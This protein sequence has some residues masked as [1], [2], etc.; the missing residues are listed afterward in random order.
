MRRPGVRGRAGARAA[1]LALALVLGGAGSVG[2]QPQDARPA[3]EVETFEYT[4]RR[5]DT[6]GSLA[7]RFYGSWRL[8]DVIERFNPAED[9]GEA[10]ECGPYLSP[11]V[12]L[13]LPREYVGGGRAARAPTPDAEVTATVRR[14]QAR[15]PAETSWRRANRGLDLFRGWRVNTLEASAAELTFRDESIV[16]MREN[17]LV[18]IYGGEARRARRETR[19]A[20]LERGALRSRLAELRGLRVETPS[21]EAELAEGEA[22]VSVDGAGTSRVSNLEGREARVRGRAG[23]RVR[24]RPGF[25]SKVMP[26]SRP[27]PPRPLP[28]APRWAEGAPGRF[29]GVS[30]EGATVRGGWAPVEGAR[31]YRVEIFRRTEAGARGSIVAATEVP[32]EV[33]RFELH[34]LPA[35]TYLARAS[36][37]DGDFFESRPS[38]ALA[39]RVELGRFEGG[40]APGEGEGEDVLPDPTVAPEPPTVWAGTRFLPPEGLRCVL[41]GAEEQEV[42]EAA[43]AAGGEAETAEPAVAETESGAERA[44]GAAEGGAGT[45]LVIARAG[46]VRCVDAEGFAAAPFGVRVE[47]PRVRLAAVEGAHGA[48]GDAEGLALV[49]GRAQRVEL[50]LDATRAPPE[51]LVLRGLGAT[52]P[53]AREGGRWVA[54]ITP[55]EG[56][57]DAAL[58]VALDEDAPAIARVPVTLREPEPA[59]DEEA[60]EADEARERAGERP[61]EPSRPPF[62]VAPALEALGLLDS[63]ELLPLR[64]A[65]PRGHAIWLAAG[66]LGRGDRGHA[67]ITLGAEVSIAE[68]VRVGLRVPT[69]HRVG[70]EAPARRGDRDLGS[71]IGASLWRR[72]ELG[73]GSEPALA[74]YG[75]LAAWWPTGVE[76]GSLGHVWLV[77]SLAFRAG[78]GERLR[79]RTRQGAVLDAKAD[80][81]MLWASAYGAD[82]V[83]H[84][85]V[86]AGLEVDLALGRDR[87]RDTLVTHLGLGGGVAAR[88][89]PLTFGAQ[90]RYAPTGDT[91]RRVGAL[92]AA[93]YVRFDLGAGPGREVAR[94]E[95]GA[96]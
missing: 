44:A 10:G 12:V 55:V 72:G 83:L 6:C 86:S 75:E 77:P 85:H 69:D 4:V 73:A 34:W 95:A 57:E 36:T 96:R 47:E 23:G 89:G 26:G 80:G 20:T 32:A 27:T 1:A 91:E 46:E 70:D 40:A 81:A 43:D 3:E 35:G 60:D 76:G 62:G 88:F 53:L 33:T 39:F 28:P 82:V 24:V 79:L 63:P 48:E 93:G 56:G 92:T 94:E 51:G 66:S 17:T 11:G 54:T 68:R 8:Y 2:A 59:G 50:E 74:L 29:V 84:R 37:I 18:I 90:L 87:A 31:A 64:D 78:L 21:A 41:G 38:R 14:V 71:S 42:G 7:Q 13:T 5:G 19:R 9:V 65:D 30:P 25:G 52:A 49:R 16:T 22:V 58:E 45:P 67:R 15:E 61:A